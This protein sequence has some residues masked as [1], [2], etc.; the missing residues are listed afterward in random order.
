MEKNVAQQ[1]WVDRLTL[2]SNALRRLTE[3]VELCHVRPLN[4]YER[5]SLIKRFEFTYEMA[6]KLLMSYEK[7]NGVEQILGSK[8]VVRHATGMTL[9]DNGEAWMDMI[10]S[11]NQ[12]SHL[13]DE[14]MTVDVVDDILHTY[15]P[16]FVALRDRMGNIRR[17]S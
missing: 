10:D 15:H 17:Q 6:W 12:T 13:Y 8:D 3:V 14:E 9:I 16:L 1:K 5:D 4:D 2:F 11:R 7:Y